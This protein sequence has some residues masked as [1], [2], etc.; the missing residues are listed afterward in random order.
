MK[1]I[2]DKEYAEFQ[3]YKLDK[4][5]DRIL[6]PD[7]LRFVCEA[8]GYDALKIGEHFIEVLTEMGW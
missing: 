5:R 6:T 7:G 8:N 3:Q 4:A 1:K 2:T